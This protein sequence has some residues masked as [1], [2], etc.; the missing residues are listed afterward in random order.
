MRRWWCYLIVIVGGGVAPGAGAA[1]VDAT[2]Q[3]SRRVELSTP[4][5]G[6]VRQVLVDAGQRVTKDQVLLTLDETPFR[7]EL[8]EAE[9]TAVR[10]RHERAEAGRELKRAKDLY[11]RTVLSTVEL[12]QAKLGFTRADTAAR[13]AEARLEAAKYRL[14]QASVRAPFDGWV[15]TRQA[16]PGQNVAARL[17]PPVLFVFAEGGAYVARARVPGDKL[18]GVGIGKEAAVTVAG[19]QYKGTVRSVGVEPVANKDKADALYEVDVLFST[20]EMTLRPGM[21]ARVELP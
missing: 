6:V 8:S 13:E 10:R 4:V 11:D 2:I 9:A 20:A 18:A 7:A 1:S 5:S 15:V 14:A 17:Q 21:G 19:K 3:W 16:E 12:D